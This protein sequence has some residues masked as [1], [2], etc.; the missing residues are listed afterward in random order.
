MKLAAP[1]C[2][3]AFLSTDL[4]QARLSKRAAAAAAVSRESPRDLQREDAHA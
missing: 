3:A 4:A 2:A 1:F